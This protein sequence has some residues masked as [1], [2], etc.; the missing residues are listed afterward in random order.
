MRM[1]GP[2]LHNTKHKTAGTV[3]SSSV[4]SKPAT[5]YVIKNGEPTELPLTIGVSDGKVTQVLEGDLKPGQEIIIDQ[6]R[7]A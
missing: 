4:T 7:G 5:V 2:P 3:S 6:R 1:F